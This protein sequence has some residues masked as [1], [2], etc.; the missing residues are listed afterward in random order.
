MILAIDIGNSNLVIGILEDDQIL[1]ESRLRTD[2][3]KTS[4]EY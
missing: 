1:F 3:T 4:Y 2:S